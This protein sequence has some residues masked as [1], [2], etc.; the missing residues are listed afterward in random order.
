M[1]NGNRGIISNGEYRAFRLNMNQSLEYLSRYGYSINVQGEY[2]KP[3][4]AIRVHDVLWKS[5]IPSPARLG[6]FIKIRYDGN[7]DQMLEMEK[8]FHRKYGGIS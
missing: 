3:S 4:E 1:E 5:V 2:L 8:G 6:A 7:V